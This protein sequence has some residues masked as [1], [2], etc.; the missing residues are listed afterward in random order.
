MGIDPAELEYMKYAAEQG[1]VNLDGGGIE[2][3]GNPV[4]EVARAFEWPPIDLSPQEGITVIEKGACSACRGTI[5]SVYVDL[6]NMG[7]MDQVRDLV[8]LVGPQAELPENLEQ[9]PLIMG[10]CLQHLKDEGRC[11]VGCPPN[12]DKMREAIF[13]L[14]GIE[15]K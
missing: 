4:E 8:M 2:V 5:R 11:V 13:E 7:V 14:T 15:P 10:V 1:L 3:V 6:E 9:T 12:N